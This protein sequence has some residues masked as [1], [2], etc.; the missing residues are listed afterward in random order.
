M[1]IAFAGSGGFGVPTLRRLAATYGVLLV[2]SQPDRPAGRGLMLTSPPTKEVAQELGIPV[3]QPR[4]INAPPVLDQL[5]ALQLDFLVVA[6]FGQF[7][8]EPVLT[9][10]KHGC[11]NIHA[12]LL[13]AYRGAAPVAWAVIRGERETGVTTFVLDEGMDTGPLLLQ[14]S[15]PIGPDETAGELERRLAQVGAD[16]I[17]ET[18]EGMAKGEIVPRPQPQEGTVAP[19][20]HKE[21]GRIRWEWEARR[22]HDLVRGTN[23]WPGAQTTLRDK[24]V[25]VH[26]TRVVDEEAGHIP[27]GAILPRRDRLLV[28]TGK[29]ILE[30]LEL[31]P[32]GCRAISG[33]EFVHG[34]CRVP[35]ERFA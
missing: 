33:P 2:V 6:A 35:G 10:P 30:I 28:A 12:S 23:P 17:V 26:R 20:L 31:Q 27:P 11:V 32:A 13:P 24:L 7:L 29:G 21:D 16:L 15:V 4:T 18:L 34:Y 22:I 8:R 9:L 3:V 25:K 19:K 1:R 14:R 5:R